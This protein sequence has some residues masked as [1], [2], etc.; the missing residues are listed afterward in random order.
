MDYGTWLSGRIEN[1]NR[2]SRHYSRQ[3]PFEGSDRQIRSF[4]LKQLLVTK[5]SP[6]E[7]IIQN[8]KED[9]QRM[10]RIIA[11]LVKEG[12]LCEKNGIITVAE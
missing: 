7:A 12:L 3:S 9:T 5:C 10:R 1:P 2:K 6:L 4:L 11:D 8:S